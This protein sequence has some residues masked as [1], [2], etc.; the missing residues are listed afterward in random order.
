M[1]LA[2]SPARRMANFGRRDT[3]AGLGRPRIAYFD[4][5][6]TRLTSL[7]TRALVRAMAAGARR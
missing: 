6:F 2:H 4:R 3:R 7:A 1:R 5:R